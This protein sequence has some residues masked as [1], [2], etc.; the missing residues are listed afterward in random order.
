[1]DHAEPASHIPDLLTLHDDNAVTVWDVRAIEEQD[2]DF[3]N[4]C[5]ATRD[6]CAAVGWRYEAF[7]RLPAGPSDHAS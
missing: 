3:R 5:A 1:M 4:K 6:A 7:R 2:E